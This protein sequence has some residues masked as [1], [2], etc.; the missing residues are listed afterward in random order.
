MLLHPS[1]LTYS[2]RY[3]F[4]ALVVLC[5]VW[6]SGLPAVSQAQGAPFTCEVVFY[7]VRNPNSS[8]TTQ[9]QIFSY[10]SISDFVAP[11]PVY[12]TPP[13]G[14]LNS[15][16]YNPVDNYMYA[17]FASAGNPRLYRI[18]QGGYQLVGNINNT[19]GAAIT[20]FTPTAGA[21][22]AAGRF[23]F[24]GQGTT[25][26][27]GLSIAPNAIFRVD[28]IPAT[29]NMNAAHQYNINTTS[30]M[31]VGDFDFNGAGGPSG[32]LLA[33]SRQTTYY[34]NTPTMHRI[35]LQ[36]STTSL[37][38]TASVATATIAG[39]G[40]GTFSI[41]SAFWDA[42]T[43]RFYVFDNDASTFW[44]IL[45]PQVGAPTA[46]PVTVPA[47]A[48]PFATNTNPTDGSSC[49][50]SGVRVADLQIQKNDF[51][52]TVATNQVVAYN[53]T[54]TNAGPYPAN[55]AVVSDPPQPGIQKLSVTCSAPGGPPS[56]VC[57]ATL[58]TSTFETGVSV[59]TFPPDTQ[60]VFTVN[61]L[62]TPTTGTVTNV[63]IV[64]APIDATDPTPS[65]NRATDTDTISGSAPTV[66]SAASMCPANTT[67][68]LTNRILNGSF[69]AA[70]PF[71]TGAAFTGAN[72]TFQSTS[73]TTTSFVAIQAGQRVYTPSF[74]IV[75]N[76]FYGDAG[77]SVVGGSNWLLVNGKGGGGNYQAWNQPV[78]LQAGTVYQ[79][80]Y[81]VSNAVQPGGTSTVVPIVRAQLTSG[82]GTFVLGTTTTT[83]GTETI[84]AGDT[85]RLVQGTFTVATAGTVTLS[86][87]DFTAVNAAEVGDV[88]ALSGIT[89]RSCDPVANV[90]ITKTDG[91]TTVSSGG[92][93][94]Y[95]IT[96]SNL[97]ASVTATTALFSDPAV[98]NF[99]KNTVTCAPS[100]G[101]LCPTPTS[102]ITV[103]NLEGSG[104]TIP[105]IA[106]NSTVTFVVGG[107][108]TGAAGTTITN[109]ATV[110]AIGFVDSDP[111]NNSAQDVDSVVGSAALSI[112]KTN[113]VTV[114]VA[115]G[116]T[117][118]S[119][120]V[121]NTGPSNVSNALFR[122]T[123][124]TG[125]SCTSISC[126]V[127]SGSALCPLPANL[128]VANMAGAGIQIPSLPS[129]SSVRFTVNCDVTATGVP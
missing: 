91:R 113:S 54:V 127:A 75:Q 85:W 67:E 98:S 111:S 115:G 3:L 39:I 48:A 79:Y 35:T 64:T 55:Y 53:I 43:S 9:S 121:T 118:Y 78:S 99:I 20:G 63:A 1:N 88:W 70:T 14:R 65:N 4:R 129:P 83:L 62:I 108:V 46:V 72:N 96:I 17:L 97:S 12:G 76:P 95:T 89:L 44:E 40:T 42:F 29:G 110:A 120:T 106:P 109:I 87:A 8:L 119:I 80:M 84:A 102:S 28:A 123:P 77:R 124:S 60:L 37:I 49:P 93:T 10:S 107:T 117:S 16:G 6:M 71:S 116:T 86:I 34:G 5:M 61:A 68:S 21:F 23:Y 105:R 32:L 18:G 31:N 125:L 82:T 126:S 56:A 24:A 38:G 81:Y 50:I 94:A 7:Q 128:T 2:A 52:T 57:P 58:S 19:T 13:V 11:N 33:A 122:D 45:N 73:A 92:T 27:I 25:A 103:L 90:R 59:L 30:I 104:L 41:G 36:P 47:P 22:D 101:S 114:L 69:S 15:L 74:T 26:G 112:T 51:N 100:A 66:V